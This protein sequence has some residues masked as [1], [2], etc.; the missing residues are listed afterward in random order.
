MDSAY[1]VDIEK[2]IKLIKC[3]R[4]R[5]TYINGLFGSG[6]TYITDEFKKDGF[7]VLS[8]DKIYARIDRSD[9]QDV[10]GIQELLVKEVH[11]HLRRFESSVP[12]I[13]EGFMKDPVVLRDIFTGEFEIFTYAYMYPNNPKRYKDRLIHSMTE[14]N[15]SFKHTPYSFPPHIV[16]AGDLDELRDSGKGA[17]TVVKKLIEINR[18]IYKKHLDAFDE[19]ILTILN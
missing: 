17:N 14:R 4:P 12:V 15:W 18:D 8:L 1:R 19:H 7:S 13:I 10:L 11:A 5:I 2:A 6:K 16:N 3:V 9:T